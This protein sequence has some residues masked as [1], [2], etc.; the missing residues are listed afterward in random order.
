MTTVA[1]SQPMYLPWPAFIEMMKLADV[2]LWLDD[3]QFSK[4]SFTNASR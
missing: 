1:I 2:F 4:G 3:A